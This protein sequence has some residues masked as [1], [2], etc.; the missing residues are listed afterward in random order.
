MEL[1][2]FEGHHPTA[3]LLLTIAAE[4]RVPARNSKNQK[5]FLARLGADVP[6]LLMIAVD[7]P[8]PKHCRICKTVTG[9]HAV[10]T[11]IVGNA[12]LSEAIDRLAVEA[13]AICYF[14]SDPCLLRMRVLR[15]S[16]PGR[17][18]CLW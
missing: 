18:C 4:L 17:C 3:R 11:Y 13:G 1:I 2:V 5:D 15:L 10:Q 6:H 14:Q 9:R 12:P 16:E 7:E 8:G